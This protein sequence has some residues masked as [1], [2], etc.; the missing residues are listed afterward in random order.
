MNSINCYIGHAC[1]LFT[2]LIYFSHSNPHWGQP[3]EFVL[4][5]G[6]TVIV[7]A[8]ITTM[9]LDLGVVMV[10]IEDRFRSRDERG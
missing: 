2:P 4:D 6:T 5:G 7:F 9:G 1:T 10:L 3:S 8:P